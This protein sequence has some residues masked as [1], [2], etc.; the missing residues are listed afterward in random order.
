VYDVEAGVS[1]CS[2][3]TKPSLDDSYFTE[4]HAHADNELVIG[5]LVLLDTLSCRLGLYFTITIL[6]YTANC[7]SYHVDIR[8]PDDQ[9]R[10]FMRAAEI[11]ADRRL[12]VLTDDLTAYVRLRLCVCMC[13]KGG[14]D[15]DRQRERERE[16]ARARL[17]A[18]ELLF[19][20]TW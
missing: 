9:V 20:P 12:H 2:L 1:S 19:R 5:S 18:L 16:S 8:C 3:V 14:G 13:V 15:R 17:A 10:S 7:F 6:Y 11:S 4:A